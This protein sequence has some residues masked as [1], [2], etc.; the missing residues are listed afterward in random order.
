MYSIIYL[1]LLLLKM[2]TNE[3]KKWVIATVDMHCCVF[4]CK[5]QFNHQPFPSNSLRKLKGKG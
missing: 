1:M 5:R 2:R 4:K 3:M